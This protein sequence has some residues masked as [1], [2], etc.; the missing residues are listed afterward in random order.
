MVSGQSGRTSGLAKSGIQEEYQ[1]PFVRHCASGFRM[2]TVSIIEKGAGSVDVSARPAFPKTRSTSGKD[3]RIWS[4]FC[5]R[6][7]A[8]V[9]EM[10]GRVVG[11]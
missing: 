10:P 2:T 8:P 1:R 11:M 4:C 6:A 3:F 7:C 9:T 5:R